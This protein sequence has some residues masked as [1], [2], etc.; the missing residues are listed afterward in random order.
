MEK[1]QSEREVDLLE[2]PG[3]LTDKDKV[4]IQESWAKVYENSVDNGVAILLRYFF[5]FAFPPVLSLE[6]PISSS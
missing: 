1:M 3:P 5:F 4:L 2:R 6:F